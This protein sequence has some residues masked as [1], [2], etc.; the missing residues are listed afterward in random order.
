MNHFVSCHLFN[1]Y[2]NVQQH[3]KTVTILDYS[4]EQKN[5]MNYDV[6]ASLMRN[7]KNFIL[8]MTFCNKLTIFGR[9]VI[10]HICF[11]RAYSFKCNGDICPNK[12]LYDYTIKRAYSF[13]CNTEKIVFQKLAKCLLSI[14]YMILIEFTSAEGVWINHYVFLNKQKS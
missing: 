9:M 10:L 4:Y 6:L 5:C 1:N 13:K 11:K 7:N 2:Q 8:K 12:A 14:F 3:T